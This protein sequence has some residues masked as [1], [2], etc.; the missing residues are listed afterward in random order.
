V[1]GLLVAVAVVL[2]L[3]VLVLLTL[4]YVLVVVSGTATVGLTPTVIS[5]SPLPLCPS[6]PMT[7]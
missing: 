5:A 1:T 4:R 2:G 7:I 3:L 6:I